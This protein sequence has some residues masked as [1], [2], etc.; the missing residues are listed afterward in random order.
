MTAF[1]LGGHPTQIPTATEN[2][3][4]QNFSKRARPLGER[5]RA[6][7]TILSLM[8]LMLAACADTDVPTDVE[9]INPQAAVIA[10]F[11]ISPAAPSVAVGASVQLKATTGQQVPVQVRWL[12]KDKAIAT[13]S[14]TGILT[15]VA[16]GNTMVGAEATDGAFV[17]V[18]VTVTTGGTTPP[19]PPPTGTLTSLKPSFMS[20]LGGGGDDMA[21]DVGTDAQGNIY[22][23]GST[24]SGNFPTT[25]GAFDRTFNSP[26]GSSNHDAFITKLSPGGQ[27]IWST[28]LGGN[29]FDRIDALEVD[30]SGFI[31]VAGRAG[32]G[33][34]VT[35]GTFQANFAGGDHGGIYGAQDGFVCK[36]RSDGTR[37]F[38]SYFGD[39]DVLAIRDI[40]VDDV[41]DI[42]SV[43]PRQRAHSRQR[44]L[45]MPSRKRDAVASIW[46]LPRSRR[47][48]AACCGRP[49]WAARPTK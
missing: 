26:A 20:Y 16:V 25:A 32:P 9:Q 4:T 11:A 12:V 6:V 36:F 17:T 38:C 45:S 37:V 1:I 48:A 47:M 42:T 31:Y 35:Q 18:P 5:G 29:G 34:P 33:F 30:K 24:T 43:R 39:S 44:G 22:I 13:I 3:S 14:S 40:A 46:S 8:T 28:F 7:G 27:M 2:Q 19:P 41:G 10:S 21:R 23:A 49:I 15:G